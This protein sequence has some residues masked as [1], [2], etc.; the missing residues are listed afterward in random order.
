MESPL[1]R[2][3]T[4]LWCPRCGRLR[5]WPALEADRIPNLRCRARCTGCGNR[6]VALRGVYAPDIGG[7]GYFGWELRRIAEAVKQAAEREQTASEAAHVSGNKELWSRHDMAAGVLRRLYLGLAR[8]ADS[9]DDVL[10]RAM[11]TPQ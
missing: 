7:I 2:C 6:D 3:V 8:E 10:R 1:T 4:V 5:T 11:T 9:R